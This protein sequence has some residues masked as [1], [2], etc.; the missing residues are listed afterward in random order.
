MGASFP[1]DYFQ[2][3]RR[4]CHRGSEKV[5]LWRLDLTTLLAISQW[6]FVRIVAREPVRL[7]NLVD[8]DANGQ[9][10]VLETIQVVADLAPV[11]QLFVAKARQT[12]WM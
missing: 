4:C 6:F 11:G 9:G 5:W 12:S 3:R 7:N 1:R 2:R 8:T 10:M